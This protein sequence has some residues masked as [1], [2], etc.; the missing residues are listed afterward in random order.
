[1]IAKCAEALA[2]RKAFPNDLSGIYSA[3]EMQQADIDHGAS[4]AVVVPAIE[5]TRLP[6]AQENERIAVVLETVAVIDTMADLVH[7]RNAS[8]DLLN[9]EYAGT[10]VRD[11]FEARRKELGA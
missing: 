4:P 8:K 5:E 6:T 10:Y 11:L 7:L 1:M 9:L 2:L 3:D